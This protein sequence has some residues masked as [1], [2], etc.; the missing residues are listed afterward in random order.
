MLIMIEGVTAL[1][2]DLDA[3][4]SWRR[5]KAAEYPD[6]TR[7]LRA[8]ELLEGLA[9]ELRGGAHADELRKV[10]KA[11]D[12]YRDACDRSKLW[13]DGLSVSAVLRPRP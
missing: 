11:I 8:A 1:A 10:Q 3:C 6:D 13:D 5:E 7:N 9:A 12:E 4:A 2:D